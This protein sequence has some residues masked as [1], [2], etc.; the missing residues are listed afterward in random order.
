MLTN[1]FARGV[2]VG[3]L[4]VGALNSALALAL[5]API[6]P[7]AIRLVATVNLPVCIVGVMILYRRELR[8]RLTGAW[9]GRGA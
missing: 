2:V 3:I 5:G 1:P 7:P 4:T 9:S 8:R 6:V